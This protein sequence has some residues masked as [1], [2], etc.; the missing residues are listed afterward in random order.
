MSPTLFLAKVQRRLWRWCFPDAVRR[1]YELSKKL[2]KLETIS[3]MLRMTNVIT[4]I[5]K[6]QGVMRVLQLADVEFLSEIAKVF[7]DNGIPYWIS[8]GTLMGAVRHG[9]F[10]PWDDDIDI[11]TTREHHNRIVEVIEKVYGK[12]GDVFAVKSDCTRIYKRGTVCQIDVFAWDILSLP[13]G[14]PETM[15]KA[16][17]IH[18]KLNL[19]VKYDFSKLD[20]QERT[21]A[22]PDDKTILEMTKQMVDA[23]SG[24]HRILVEGIEE[25]HRNFFN[26]KY[27]TIFPLKKIKLEGREFS[28]PNDPEALLWEIYGDFMSFPK[29]FGGHSNILPKIT[30]DMKRKMLSMLKDDLIE[31]L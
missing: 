30:L 1:Y 27:E 8:S 28:C 31:R 24:P 2:D 16:E 15:A 26:W 14:S 23:F 20:T 10:I 4:Q 25:S 22:S 18:R 21:I 5:P 12:N 19:E 3:D 6:A 29:S 17:A 13:D 11:C 9:G 7:D